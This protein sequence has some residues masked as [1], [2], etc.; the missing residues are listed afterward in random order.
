MRPSA[1]SDQLYALRRFFRDLQEWGWIPVRFNPDRCLRT[2]RSIANLLGPDPKPIDA[3]VWAK[4]VKAALELEAEDFG[5]SHDYPIEMD[6]TLAA[7]WVCSGLRSDE[8]YRLRV[9][10]V[11]WQRR[12]VKVRETGEVLGKDSVCFLD[13]PVNKTST[14]FTKPVPPVVGQRI[15]EWERARAADQDA[16]LDDKT[17]EIVQFLFSHRNRRPGKEYLNQSLISALCRK[18]GVPREDSRGRITSHRARATVAS[19]LTNA[20][21]PWNLTEI[22]AFLGHT[23]PSSTRY[24]VELDLTRLA[25]KFA[26]SGYLEKNLATVEVLLDVEALTSGENGQALYYELGHG[27]C[28]NPYWHKCPY[29]MACVKCPMYVPGEEAQYV[30]AK[31]GVR[32]MLETIP[33]TDEERRAAQGDEEALSQLLGKSESVPV[34]ANIGAPGQTMAPLLKKNKKTPD[35]SRGETR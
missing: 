10:C 3:H 31:Q 13:V 34:P 32:R 19:Q 1:K 15:E 22:Q 20:P 25:K 16:A 7:L 8:I 26:D 2:P 21:D 9:G 27:L 4:L 24:Y 18:A 30:R 33:L 14:A 29:R 11:R 35:A 28:A 17:G 12:D 23:N 5:K 6:R